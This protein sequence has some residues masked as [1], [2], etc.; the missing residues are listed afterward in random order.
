MQIDSQGYIFFLIYWPK[1]LDILVPLIL[2]LSQLIKVEKKE[3]KDFYDSFMKLIKLEEERIR[4]KVCVGVL[5]FIWVSLP[6]LIIV[7]AITTLSEIH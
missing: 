3:T 6:I 7:I 4:S 2:P 1:N 5:L